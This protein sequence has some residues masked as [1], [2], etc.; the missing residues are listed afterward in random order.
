MGLEGWFGKK[1]PEVINTPAQEEMDAK[2]RKAK[3]GIGVGLGALGAVIATQPEVVDLHK[4][5]P[6]HVQT[7]EKGELQ[8][9]QQPQAGGPQVTINPT[10]GRAVVSIPAPEQTE[11]KAA[12]VLQNREPVSIDLK[13]PEPKSIDLS[14]RTYTFKPPQ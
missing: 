10:E 11:V 1:Q 12:D 4:G 3:I 2:D 14:T 8:K 7:M 6:A 5:V 9:M 13:G